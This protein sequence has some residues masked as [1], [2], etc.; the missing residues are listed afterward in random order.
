MKKTTSIIL[1]LIAI[2]FFSCESQ[3]NTAGA[4]GLSVMAY[5]YAPR[6][7]FN[8][9]DLPLDKLTHIIYSF[10]EVIDNEMKFDDDSSTIKLKMLVKEK[11][12]HPHLKVMIACG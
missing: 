5:Y 1:S 4:D 2:S 9:E 11:K 6:G 7:N 10:T 12:N 8:P 3:E